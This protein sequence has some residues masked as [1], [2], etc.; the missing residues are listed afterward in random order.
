[1]SHYEH[2]ISSGTG[3]GTI[4]TVASPLFFLG[5]TDVDKLRSQRDNGKAGTK[6]RKWVR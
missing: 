5:K 1:M 2:R 4:M 3:L 6:L